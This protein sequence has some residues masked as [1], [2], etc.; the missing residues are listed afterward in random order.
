MPEL[1][2]V[3][4]IRQDLK[5][6]ILGKKIQKI[7][8]KQSKSVKNKK[9]YFIDTLSGQHF[10][11]IGRQGKL[12]V[13]HL[14]DQQ[15]FLLSHLRMTGQLI[16]QMSDQVI[17]GGHDWPDVSAL[18]NKHSH[19]ILDFADNSQLFFND[20]R[21]F[22]YMQLVN[23]MELEKIL[24]RFGIE[25]LQANFTFSNFKKVFVNKKSILKPFLLNQQII[26]GL[27]NIYVDEICHAAKILPD[28]K[29]DTLSEV[30]LKKLYQATE[31][32]IQKAILKRGTTFS[33]YRDASGRS[34]N[35]VDYLKVYGRGGEKCLACGE[36]LKKV[37]LG[38]RGTTFCPNCQ[39]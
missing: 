20:L 19:I 35:F 10:V 5:T 3:E 28:R 17:A 36:T 22:G 6:K 32:I 37:K 2:E 21:R 34:G 8:V 38:G 7:Q 26:S 15:N 4:T 31:K 23:A 9:S 33:D 16:Y 39:K 24:E 30:E 18:P 13:F 12:L 29:I 14:A 25:P 27:G 1:P 11:D